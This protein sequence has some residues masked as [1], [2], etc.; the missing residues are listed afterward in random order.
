MH[1]PS[2]GRRALLLG[3]AAAPL[4]APLPTLAQPA[5]D[6]LVDAFES[7]FGQHPG[8][9]RSFAKG[10]CAEGR[11]EAAP[12]ARG[13]T[14]SA[15]FAGG[16]AVRALVRFSVGGGNPRAPDA[17]RS[18]RG[19]AV[20]FEAAGGPGGGETWDT[21]SI[22]APVFFANTP[23]SFVR[24]FEAR[25]PD[26]QTRMP[27]PQT[28]AAAN[29]AHPDWQP[30]LRHLAQN[31]PPASWATTPYWGTNAFVFRNAAGEV[32]HA[33]WVFEPAAGTRRL[34]DEELRAAPADFLADELRRRIA[35]A[36]VVFDLFAILAQPGDS[37]TDPTAEWPA[38]R[39]RAR[40]GRLA[41]ASAGA[42]AGPGGACDGHS[43][44]QLESAPGIEGV[45]G[46][47]I[48]QA[49]TPSYAVSLGRRS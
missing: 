16:G 41:I 9:R 3:A 19:L 6:A 2:L 24:F 25:R 36:P 27:N 39:P 42:G 44:L 4:V 5:P 15:I 40:L 32:R 47:R 34:S 37:L 45:E 30:Q 10:L 35:Q 11:F 33:R 49:R 13:L 26:P 21:A 14:S 7:L 18:V 48:F 28:V 31:N 23:E 17:S 20:R 43:F 1:R 12:E 22:S 8:F 38:D 46:D 29:A